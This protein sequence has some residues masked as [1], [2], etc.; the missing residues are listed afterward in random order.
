MRAPVSQHSLVVTAFALLHS[1][2]APYTP[3][4]EPRQGCVVLACLSCAR[5]K[6]PD[7]RITLSLRTLEALGAHGLGCLA[8]W[9]VQGRL[10][11][12]LGLP[13]L[14]EEGVG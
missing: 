4:L 9:G 10:A 6:R 12:G 1:T 3:K 11:P 13:L 2:T 5:C 14:D 7:E 8:P